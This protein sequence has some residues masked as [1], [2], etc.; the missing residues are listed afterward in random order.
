MAG[1]LTDQISE[2]NAKVTDVNGTIVSINIGLNVGFKAG[3]V[4]EIVRNNRVIATSKLTQVGATFAVGTVQ[5]VAGSADTPRPG[6]AVRRA[7]I[8]QSPR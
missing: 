2:V 3:D 8:S 4:I 5:S 1:R 7:G 6:D